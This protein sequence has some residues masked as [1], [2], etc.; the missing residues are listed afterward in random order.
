MSSKNKRAHRDL[1]AE[2][3]FKE[4]H[5][6]LLCCIRHKLVSGRA[7]LAWIFL[8]LAPLCDQAT[9]R[10]ALGAAIVAKGG[11]IKEIKKNAYRVRFQTTGPEWYTVRQTARGWSC[12]C[13]DHQYRKAYCKHICAVRLLQGDTAASVPKT[14][15]ARRNTVVVLP[16]EAVPKGCI[17]CGAP[18]IIKKGFHTV[19]YSK[20]GRVQRYGCKGC[21]RR[22][23]FRPGFERM[24]HDPETVTEA[25]N[26]YNS[27][28]SYRKA[29]ESVRRRGTDVHF[30]TIYRWNK[31]YAALT[32]PYLDSLPVC[33]GS[34]WNAD[35]L[36]A[37]V[38]RLKM[39]LFSVM[40]GSTRFCLSH[41]MGDRKDGY[42]A[43]RL[44]A[45][46]KARAGKTPR[47]FVSDSLPSYGYAFDKVFAASH[48][49]Q[50]C[51]HISEARLRGKKNNNI[52]ERLN[53]TFRERE[54]ILRGIK[55]AGS[56][57]IAGFIT[58]YNF[59]RPHM[60][61]GGRTPAEAAGIKIT[62]HDKWM[63]IIGNAGLHRLAAARRAAD[64]TAA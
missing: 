34:R 52:E 11:Q 35:E 49:R 64:V 7:R 33:V 23:V 28:L 58:H 37:R 30:T 54:K 56:P 2:S 36:Y 20:A 4:A 31:K 42:N 9:V 17:W 21:G 5:A 13:P 43:E 48:P 1:V 6:L 40:D 15:G 27:G 22:F 63:T 61:L 44:L 14:S 60:G 39:Y 16:I 38:K 19:K 26:Q 29:V 3:I 32:G 53:G 12:R 47:V 24:R 10:E 62:G 57:T 8:S 50:K 45:V 55:M 25:L 59:V 41:D 46:A 51:R 18:D